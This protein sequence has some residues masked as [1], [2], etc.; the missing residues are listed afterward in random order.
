MPLSP[1]KSR[2]VTAVFAC[3]AGTLAVVAWFV[4]VV[5]YVDGVDLHVFVCHARD[6]LWLGTSAEDSAYR[7]FPG[8][9]AFWRF[10]LASFGPED[11]PVQTAIVLILA[12]NTLLTGLIA[13]RL[14]GS[15][16]TATAAGCLYVCLA[17]RFECLSGTA[18]PLATI[19]F[20]AGVLAWSWW[21]QSS[22]TGFVLLGIGFGL[23]LYCKQQAGLLALG[24]VWL[25]AAECLRRG[26]R[27]YTRIFKAVRELLVTAVAAVLCFG[28][29]VLL[30]GHGAAPVYSGLKMVS[31]YSSAGSF[32]SNLYDIFRNDESIGL[33]AGTIAGAVAWPGFGRSKN[34][35]RQDELRDRRPGTDSERR[36]PTSTVVGVLLCA[37]AAALLQFRTRGYYHYFLLIIPSLVIP[38]TVALWRA[39]S[40]LESY[41][42]RK[43][44]LKWL[45]LLVAAVPFGH[46]GDRDLDFEL[47]DPFV[48]PTEV[49]EMPVWHREAAIAADLQFLRSRV[50]A[51][52][53]LLVLP[54]VRA[55]IYLQTGGRQSTGYA[56]GRDWAAAAP[57]LATLDYVV[58]MRNQDAR[59]QTNWKNSA[60]DSVMLKLQQHGFREV[61]TGQRMRLLVPPPEAE[62]PAN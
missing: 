50:P 55:A 23:A 26:P 1:S 10:V 7:Y 40:V 61:W 19:W 4:S 48:R 16:V 56:F 24:A 18:E 54:P 52:S 12:T 45:V 31:R 53:E 15:A 43:A 47:W 33:M 60:C 9:Y 27:S 59:E 39:W 8:V 51:G 41:P 32:L 30:E 44:D 58:V 2:Q 34:G 29:L 35:K 37:G 38:F 36:T 11:A 3:V 22:A 49:A 62:K 6:M 14:T 46:A 20:L 28:T 17:S 42:G 13:F 5:R 21:P 57:D 25:V